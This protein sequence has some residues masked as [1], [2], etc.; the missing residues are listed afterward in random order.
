MPAK[1][2]DPAFVFPEE[3]DL[4][5]IRSED[6]EF[7]YGYRILITHDDS[8]AE[9]CTTMPLTPDDFLD[10]QEGDRFMQG[11]PH[12]ENTG[13]FHSIFSHVHRNTPTTVV[14]SDVKMV[15]GIDG[16]P[17]PAP[18]IA[19]IPDVADP[20]KELASFDVRKEGT[21]PSFILEVVSPK[22]RRED[23]K[24]KVPVYQRAGVYE[25]FILDSRR[26]KGQKRYE[27]TGYR[28]R[29]KTYNEINSDEPTRTDICRPSGDQGVNWLY[30]RVNNVWLGLSKERDE[31]LITDGQ[32][33]KR[34]LPAESRADEAMHQMEQERLG[35]EQALSQMEQ[36]RLEKEQALSQMEQERPEK[37]QALSQIERL[38]AQ[39]RASG[40]EPDE[41]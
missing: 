33:G 20:L 40:I 34:I 29:G 22:Y 23:T 30:S 16:L 9:I 4:E 7:Y 35:K 10:P 6:D 11:R 15:W 25:Y 3:C 1:S 24:K 39:L 28:L 38:M 31:V 17:G 26:R 13:A 5:D 12:Y 36:E 41:G 2:I 8:G 18:D 19:V 14:L 32:T 27:I 37:E 21:R